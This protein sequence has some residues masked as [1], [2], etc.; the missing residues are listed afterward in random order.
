MAMLRAAVCVALLVAHAAAIRAETTATALR[1]C[2]IR[3]ES[4]IIANGDGS[5]IREVMA[6]GT[7]IMY[8][9]ISPDGKKI[10]VTRHLGDIERVIAIHD[11]DTGK[12]TTLDA[13]PEKNCFGA[14]W[15]PD[16]QWLCFNYLHDKEWEVAVIKADNTD[17]R[18]VT[19]KLDKRDSAYPMY[20]SNDSKFL[21]AYDFQHAY[22]VDLDGK[23]M[24]R[25][26]IDQVL[27]DVEMSSGYSFS[28][29]SDGKRLLMGAL[30]EVDD[31]VPE[32][33]GPPV[34][35]FELNLDS[36]DIRRATPEGWQSSNPIYLP[37]GAA[38]VCGMWHKEPAGVYRVPLDG[39]K[40]ELLIRDARDPS[41][42]R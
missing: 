19:A 24:L 7:D 41:V 6:A 28:L 22:Q 8:P 4:V 11:I 18:I 39:G 23:E 3:G 13:I 15:S 12:A 1:V 34:M 9:V 27:K 35:V 10:A 26:P 29:S 30:K 20:W 40:P 17:F 38:F 14:V 32:E 25:K 2:A 31:I 5:G 16:G 36:G 37:D 42:S 21:F 33:G